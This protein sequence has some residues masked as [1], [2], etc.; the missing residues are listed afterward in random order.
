MMRVSL[1]IVVTLSART[2][3]A[4]IPDHFFKLH[5]DDIDRLGWPQGLPLDGPKCLPDGGTSLSRGDAARIA[6]HAS[7]SNLPSSMAF[8]ILLKERLEYEPVL[9]NPAGLDLNQMGAMYFL[10]GCSSEGDA[11]EWY[12]TSDEARFCAL[13]GPIDVSLEVMDN[14]GPVT[15]DNWGSINLNTDAVNN[16][17]FVASTTLSSQMGMC[18]TACV[19]CARI[20]PFASPSRER[21]HDP[22]VHPTPFAP[23]LRTPSLARHILPGPH[24]SDHTGRPSLA[25]HMCVDAAHP[26]SLRCGRSYTLPGVIEENVMMDWLNE[27]STM[28][29]IGFAV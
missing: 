23:S 2:A 9:V 20:S 18:A 7:R 8:A 17:T 12:R 27:Y 25:P 21:P 10:N 22:H 11:F 26:P 5:A 13:T 15:V 1:A 3:R 28:E 4:V 6:V 16:G 19:A 14:G 29:E 24:R